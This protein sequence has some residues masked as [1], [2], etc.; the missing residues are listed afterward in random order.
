V[1]LFVDVVVCCCCC[2]CLLLLVLV[3]V[4][5]FAVTFLDSTVLQEFFETKEHFSFSDNLTG[6]LE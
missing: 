2:C 1:F 3:L 6:L 4:G 5:W